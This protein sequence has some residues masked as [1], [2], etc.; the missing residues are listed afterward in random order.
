[1]NSREYLHSLFGLSGRRAVVTGASSGLGAEMAKILASAG[2]AVLAVAR[3]PERLTQLARDCDGMDGRIVIHQADLRDEAEVVSVGDAVEA[4]LGG[5]DIVVANAGTIERVPLAESHRDQFAKVLDLNVTSQWLLSRVLFPYLKAS[6]AGRVINM[7]SNMA[8]GANVR[9]GG[10]SYS[11]SKHAL[12]GLTRSQAV[13][14]APHGITANAIA[15]GYF[16]TEMTQAALE[17]RQVAEHVLRFSPMG[18]FGQPSELAPA[19]LFLASPA[20]SYVTGTIIPVDG[21][22]T[23]W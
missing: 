23:A 17:N 6:D 1:M 22:W 2:A 12:L 20:S 4:K 13:E 18:R 21:G 7:A 5:C 14:W 8:L 19:L 11:V 10:G 3:R 9:T 15:P 16:P